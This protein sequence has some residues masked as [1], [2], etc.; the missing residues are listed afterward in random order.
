MKSVNAYNPTTGQVSRILVS[1]TDAPNLVIP[2]NDFIDIG[3]G[4]CVLRPADLPFNHWAEKQVA[5]CLAEGLME[6]DEQ[7][8]FHG[9]VDD[10]YAT[11]IQLA[12]GVQ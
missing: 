3:N 5:T 11:A 12:K 6:V 4:V 9:T 8:N 10:R 7:G 1:E 2:M